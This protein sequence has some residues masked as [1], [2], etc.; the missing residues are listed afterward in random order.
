MR[1]M[2]DVVVGWFEKV[3]WSWNEFIVLV[4]H[5]HF[6]KSKQ[7]LKIKTE[8]KFGIQAFKLNSLKEIVVC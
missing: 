6:N 2:L 1:F 4:T 8:I 3:H 5:E 7:K